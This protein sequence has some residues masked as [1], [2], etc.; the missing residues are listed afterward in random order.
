MNLIRLLDDKPHIS[1]INDSVQS[2]FSK[3]QNNLKN[4]Y[5]C[6]EDQIYN[7]LQYIP[8]L[9]KITTNNGSYRFN[10]RILKDTS[11]VIS[12][13]LNENPY[14][15][16]YHLD[17]NDNRNILRKI[18]L[19]YQGQSVL[20]NKN[21]YPL[22]I[23][24]L[25]SLDIK[26]FPYNL[27]LESD[28]FI[29]FESEDN[30]VDSFST[31]IKISE[32]DLNQYLL[33]SKKKFVITTKK[34]HYKCNLYGVLTSEVIREFFLKNPKN[35]I[36]E[37]D[38]SDEYDEFQMISDIFNFE[39][40]K[41]TQENSD[42]LYNLAEELRIT[43]ILENIQRI[44][45]SNEKVNQ[46]IDEQQ[47]IVDLI[48]QLF[49]WLYNIKTLTVEKVKKLILESKWVTTDDNVKE[50]TAFFI[51][52]IN[53]D[54]Q[55]H[56]QLADLVIELNKEADNNSN[57]LSIFV[58]FLVKKLMISFSSNICKCSFIYNLQKRGLIEK[59]EI[60]GK[61]S[62]SIEYYENNRVCYLKDSKIDNLL[63]WFLPEI[64]E[65]KPSFFQS[66][67]YNFVFTKK[68]F[69]KMFVPDK[70]DV[71]KEIRDSGEPDD[72][73]TKALR[74]D[75]LDSF[76]Q[77]VSS[78]LKY[79]LN[80][81]VPF[82]MFENYV[83]NGKTSYINYA[84]AY[85][86]IKCFKYLLLNHFEIDKLT[87]N[88]AIYGR[89]I[90]IIKIVD[91]KEVE[92]D[93]TMNK[94]ILPIKNHQNNL[95]DWIYETKYPPNIKND[96][97]VH[98]LV[99]VSIA[100]GNAHA[101]I[102]L[103]NQGY[104]F[105]DNPS[106]CYDFLRV[107]SRNGFYQMTKLLF[108]LM[109]VKMEFI[110][111]NLVSCFEP[112]AP[113]DIRIKE[114]NNIC[115]LIQRIPSFNTSIQIENYPNKSNSY[116]FESA[117]I[118]ENI[119]IF[120][121]YEPLMNQADFENIIKTYTKND[122]HF[123]EEIIKS[124]F[125]MKQSFVSKIL[126]Y[127]LMQK[128]CYLFNHIID[129][130][131]KNTP[132]F[133]E[134]YNLDYEILE[135]A[136]RYQH[137][138]A[139]KL[140]IDSIL[141]NYKNDDAYLSHNFTTSFIEAFESSSFEI[142]KYFIDKKIEIDYQK[143]YF[144]VYK[145]ENID[146]GILS[147]LIDAAPSFCRKELMY[148]FIDAAMKTKSY[149]A[150]Y[151]LLKSNVQMN[152]ALFEAVKTRDIEM[153]N[154][155]LRYNSKPSFIN[156]IS[157][158]GTALH[159]A[160]L[161]QNIDVIQRLLSLPGIDVNRVDKEGK[162]PLKIACNMHN[163]EIVKILLANENVDTNILSEDGK[164][165]LIS[166][167]SKNNIELAKLL[168]KH[169]KTD[170]N[171][172]MNERT[173]LIEAV[174]KNLID[175]V[176]LLISNDKF[177]PEES[178]L[179]YAFFISFGKVPGLLINIKSLDVNYTEYKKT[180]NQLTYVTTLT[181]A[182]ESNLNEKIDLI[183]NHHS[184]DKDKSDLSAALFKAIEKNNYSAFRK[185][186]KFV[187]NYDDI[188]SVFTILNNN[189]SWE[190][191]FLEILAFNEKNGKFIDFTKNL[192]NEK[193]FF[194]II[195]FPCCKIQEI[196]QLYL[197]NGAD[198][199]LPDGFGVYPLQH[200]IEIN[201]FEYVDAL[202]KSNKIDF[203]IKIKKA[204][205]TYYEKV[206]NDFI[207]LNGKSEDDDEKSRI[208]GKCKSYLHLAARSEKSEILSLFLNKKLIDVN[209]KDS[210]DVT[211]L[212]EACMHKNIRNIELLF[213]MDDLD[214]LHRNKN[215]EDALKIIAEIFDAEIPDQAINSK[216]EYKMRLISII[217]GDYVSNIVQI[218]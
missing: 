70:I 196:V 75:D 107:A 186:L 164:F 209:I 80:S 51:Q 88:Y 67:F 76:Q 64:Y 61:I 147:L 217:K 17:I 168:I 142:C 30:S 19:M 109:Q 211:P 43:A 201:S 21:D 158:Q 3:K 165:L 182:I 127:S 72:E 86:S 149:E 58:P 162:T 203:E 189:D 5:I 1:F 24:V 218:I 14:Q 93:Q 68:N 137:I 148:N 82:N 160:I 69:T 138:D 9:F 188:S 115:K 141:K 200:A 104:D 97:K 167:I 26:R 133:F 156:K 31:R 81:F 46:I 18:E 100:S 205:K 37:F 34:R 33:K 124:G 49:E 42:I 173:A 199:N 163:D 53:S 7:I 153:V 183:I 194:T 40:V 20:F 145:F 60:I 178:L 128:D 62:E 155:V 150:V 89:N 101:L 13:I 57:K 23:A 79:Y 157:N 71:Y 92:D 198:P 122:L 108:I 187:N 210:Q 77:L 143:I 106:F 125:K 181:N 85:G 146:L 110:K 59:E 119:S 52:V 136:C 170:I 87:F 204:K 90:E 144:A 6:L 129:E 65:I 94:F 180:L 2:I 84:A 193:S 214:Y 91:Q 8:K 197:K 28:N 25:K 216:E 45:E 121:L 202:I 10:R 161:Y 114:N 117:F 152:N 102:E 32:K 154:T 78:N 131:K 48:E 123:F 169:P 116:Y 184:F 135:I 35:L 185:L 11:S 139:V 83:E 54:L 206:M 63:I 190:D 176:S 12:K 39:P 179:D 126:C 120:I 213:K 151:F 177:D 47:E 191:L 50:L 207:V 38:F 99:Y 41:I 44:I 130:F 56:H 105:A 172:G 15:K 29:F 192:K 113:F 112:I 140:V 27:L 215:G 111:G 195:R 175:I 22:L 212:M 96:N 36:Y 118:Y 171:L 95:F 98:F 55:L 132:D 74:N 16:E 134:V 174:D 103:I 166:A 208:S 159:V 66:D 4:N 73:I